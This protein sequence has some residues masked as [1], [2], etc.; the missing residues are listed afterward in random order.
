[1]SLI[2]GLLIVGLSLQGLAQAE[3]VEIEENLEIDHK[4]L[5]HKWKGGTHQEI[6][7]RLNLTPDQ[8]V[9]IKKIKE[10]YRQS[11]LEKK[12][13]MHHARVDLRFA[14]I[15]EDE[16]AIVR[17]YYVTVEERAGALRGL[18]FDRSMAFRRVLNQ[19][20]RR[21]AAPLLMVGGGRHKRIVMKKFD[22]KVFMKRLKLK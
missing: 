10:E 7:N 18:K 14:I 22:D 2:K 13:A 17:G 21:K 9:A 5:I 15:S 12:K 20:Q 19:E 11:I 16:E 1:M 3:T 6:M 4:A 8:K